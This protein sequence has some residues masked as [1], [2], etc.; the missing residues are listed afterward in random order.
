MKTNKTIFTILLLFVIF[1][2][3]AQHLNKEQ[4]A[5]LI[6]EQKD[7]IEIFTQEEKNNLDRWFTEEV[8]KMNLSKTKYDD[9]YNI[10]FSYTFKMS[11][12]DDKDL[13]YTKEMIDRDFEILL[14]KQDKKIK[15]ILTDKE[16]KIHSEFYTKLIKNAKKRI[17]K[18]NT[19]HK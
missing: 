5:K 8:D 2:L 6:E 10:I 1:S 18:L 14:K 13:D 17:K 16:Y 4:K 7:K 19:E 11:R 12:L 3:N 15:A 9:Y